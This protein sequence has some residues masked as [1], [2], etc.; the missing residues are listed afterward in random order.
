M[1]IIVVVFLTGHRV[2]VLFAA[3]YSA[4][5]ALAN[6]TYL[7]WVVKTKAVLVTAVKR[8]K[9][10]MCHTT[11]VLVNVHTLTWSHLLFSTYFKLFNSRLKGYVWCS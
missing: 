4:N 7:Y 1:Y 2:T 9:Y 8:T 10:S 6:I 11:L 5:I 3:A